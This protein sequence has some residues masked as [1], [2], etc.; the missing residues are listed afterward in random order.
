MPRPPKR[1]GEIRERR[2][3]LPKKEFV[4]L[5]KGTSLHGEKKKNVHLTEV[6]TLEGD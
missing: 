6:E 4:I 3:K 2:G 1:S 5:E